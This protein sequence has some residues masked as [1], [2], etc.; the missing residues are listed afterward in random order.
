[1]NLNITLATPLDPI[2]GSRRKLTLRPLLKTL[3]LS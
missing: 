3:N 1:M 2:E